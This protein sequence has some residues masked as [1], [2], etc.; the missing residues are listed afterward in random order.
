MS[1]EIHTADKYAFYKHLLWDVSFWS[2]LSLEKLKYAPNPSSPL[3][4]VSTPNTASVIL[5]L[6]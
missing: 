1:T 6:V 5:E 4:Q 2:M 3:L